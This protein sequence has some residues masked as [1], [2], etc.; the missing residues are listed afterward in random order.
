MS[1]DFLVVG[2]CSSKLELSPDSIK[3][4]PCTKSSVVSKNNGLSKSSSPSSSTTSPLY[5][6]S[7]CFIMA[8]LVSSKSSSFDV[9]IDEDTSDVTAA[10][11]ARKSTTTPLVFPVTLIATSN[12]MAAGSTSSGDERTCCSCCGGIFI[13]VSLPLALVTDEASPLRR[14][15][16]S[17]MRVSLLAASVSNVSASELPNM[18][19]ERFSFR[20][21]RGRGDRIE[22]VAPEWAAIDAWGRAANKDDSGVKAATEVNPMIPAKAAAKYAVFMVD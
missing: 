1:V 15:R 12:I 8:R 21:N 3:S 5:I 19:N 9:V 11:L 2:G 16:G 6:C 10:S 20:G 7:A 13:S 18:D 22:I 17:P 14:M 4:N